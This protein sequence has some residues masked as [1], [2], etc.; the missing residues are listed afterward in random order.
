MLTETQIRKY[1]NVC[2]CLVWGVE[3]GGLLGEELLC[4]ASFMGTRM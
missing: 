1:A 3:G 2:V 4:F